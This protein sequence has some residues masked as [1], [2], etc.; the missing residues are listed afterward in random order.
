MLTGTSFLKYDRPSYPDHQLAGY[1]LRI[2]VTAM[3]VPGPDFSLTSVVEIWGNNL[4]LTHPATRTVK[5]SWAVLPE[6]QCRSVEI[7]ELLLNDEVTLG[8][9]LVVFRLNNF[10]LL[11]LDLLLLPPHHDLGKTRTSRR[12]MRS[13]VGEMYP[14]FPT[15]AVEN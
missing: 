13:K 6:G 2:I 11:F 1:D 9:K 8:S 14:P 3:P 4:G 15:E 10:P 12:R 7:L 5:L